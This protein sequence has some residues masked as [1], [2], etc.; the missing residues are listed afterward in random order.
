[1]SR[2][3]V[4]GQWSGCGMWLVT[5]ND[6]ETSKR[7][8]RE[9]HGATRACGGRDTR[10]IR[11]GGRLEHSRRHRH[12][13]CDAPRCHVSHSGCRPPSLHAPTVL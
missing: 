10:G 11:V 7:K 8:V 9:G 5:V 3:N 2:D 1:M 4:A 13:T 6:V 12:S